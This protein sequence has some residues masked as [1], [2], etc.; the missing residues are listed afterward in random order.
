MST[1]DQDNKPISN[2]ADRRTMTTDPNATGGPVVEDGTTKDG[3][4]KTIAGTTHLTTNIDG[5]WYVCN[6]RGEPFD[7]TQGFTTESDAVAEAQRMNDQVAGKQP[8]PETVYAPQPGQSLGTRE[9]IVNPNTIGT[10]P[11]PTT[12]NMKTTAPNVAQPAPVASRSNPDAA[13]VKQPKK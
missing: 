11:N 10:Q 6:T 13:N 3:L 5:K 12:E 1:H 9:P 8:Q 2:P 7:F 4:T